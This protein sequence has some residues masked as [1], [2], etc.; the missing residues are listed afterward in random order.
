MD[1][2]Q[3]KFIHITKCAGSSIEEAGKKHNIHWGCYDTEYITNIK[4]V[5]QW[6]RFLSLVDEK[7]RRKYDWFMIVRDPYDRILSEYYCTHN[8]IENIIHTREEMNKYLI[9]KINTFYRS[10][11]H[12]TP[13][14][15]YLD[16]S[17]K[18]HILRFE[19]LEKEFN[20]LMCLYNLEHVVLEKINV[21][22]TKVYNKTRF[23][24][25]DFSKKLID[26]INIIYNKDF[27][28][29]NYKKI[30]L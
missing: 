12:Y 11:D 2:K 4:E 25:A 21:R 18:I 16:P 3:L 7:T 10:G 20:D 19:N 15:M 17:T 27:E 28:I 26:L 14:Y 8:G 6:H 5:S 23:T 1:K 30:E 24:I 9:Q 29:F 22:N 13:Q